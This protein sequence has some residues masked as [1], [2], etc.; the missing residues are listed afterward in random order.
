M[1]CKRC[2]APLPESGVCQICHTD[3]AKQRA[4]NAQGKDPGGPAAFCKYCGK[5]LAFGEICGCRAASPKGRSRQSG[6]MHVPSQKLSRGGKIAVAAVLALLVLA[7]AVMVGMDVVSAL[8]TPVASKEH[9]APDVK[10][11]AAETEKTPTTELQPTEPEQPQDSTATDTEATENTKENSETDTEEAEIPAQPQTR[12]LSRIS[13]EHKPDKLTYFV[14]QEPDLRGLTLTA[15]YDSG[16]H[17]TIETGFSAALD[18]SN[19]GTQAVTVQYLG[20]T[21]TYTVTVVEPELSSIELAQYPTA[22][23]RVGDQLNTS[24]IVLRAKYSDGSTVDGIRSGFSCEPTVFQ[25]AGT[26]TVTVRYQG[27]SANFSVLVTAIPTYT[28]R[29][30]TSNSGYGSVSGGGIY[31][32]GQS[33]TIR[34]NANSGCRFAMWNDGETSSSRTI[35]MEQNIELTAVFYGPVSEKWVEAARIPDGAMVVDEQT[36]YRY[37]ELQMTTADTPT[38]SG[39][40]CTGSTR[41]WSNWDS[42]QQTTVKPNESETLQIVGTSVR[43]YA[44]YHYC[45]R[46]SDGSTGVDSCDVDGSGRRH[47][48]YTGSELPSM[49]INADHG[50]RESE[51]KGGCGN[52]GGCSWNYYA[53]WR[54]PANDEYTYAYQTRSE[55]TTYTFSRYTDWSTWSICDPGWDSTREVETRTVYRYRPQ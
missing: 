34:A 6:S 33:V 13:V 36:Q 40:T 28:I 54:D 10:T 21:T 18:S 55:I 23:L 17:E 3:H 7:V 53:W 16:E 4:A 46:Y 8:S 15:T 2:G 50:R 5:K 43:K 45:N 14:G 20:E 30:S 32:Q 48:I 31:E 35:R 25:S 49:Y 44:Y 19:A 1:Y 37:R 38:L 27:K 12:T 24:A 42:T 41:S 9:T 26:K 51:V 11:I 39:W 47:T 52:A 29:L 22:E